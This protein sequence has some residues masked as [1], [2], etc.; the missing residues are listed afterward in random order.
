MRRSLLISAAAV[1]LA[2][3]L[4]VVAGAAPRQIN[5][6]DDFFAPS[7]PPTRILEPGPSFRWSNGRGTA[8]DHNVRQDDRL[9]CSGQ[10][11]HRA[12]ST[13][14]IRAS[15]G[16]YALSTAS[17]MPSGTWPAGLRSSRSGGPLSERARGPWD[18][19]RQPRAPTPARLA[20]TCASSA[21]AATAKIMEGHDTET[22]RS[23]FGTRAGQSRPGAT[24]P[25]APHDPGRLLGERRAYRL[26]AQRLVAEAA[27]QHLERRHD[28]RDR[29]ALGSVP[30]TT[31]CEPEPDGAVPAAIG[32]RSGTLAVQARCRRS[33]KT[34]VTRRRARRPSSDRCRPARS[35]RSPAP[36]VSGRRRSR[37]R[38]PP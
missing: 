32:P 27:G 10:S 11:D 18:D 15:A 30:Y 8:N 26:Q 3:A 24:V 36:I 23:V 9:F 33:S 35:A 20:P 22:F 19:A 31:R 25:R 5:V 38:N 2:L 13:S 16:S 6:A 28:V 29:R 34:T 17:S 14:T 37:P 1:A 21:A 4:P 7:N 12:R